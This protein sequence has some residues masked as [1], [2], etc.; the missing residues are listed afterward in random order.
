[1]KLF[2]FLFLFLNL[3]LLPL[4]KDGSSASDEE[5]EQVHFDFFEAMLFSNGERMRTFLTDD[6]TLHTVVSS[7]DGEPFLRQAD[8]QAFLESVENTKAGALDELL[9]SFNA[10]VDGDLATAWMAYRFYVVSD[11]SH[12]GVNTMNLIRQNSEWK[13]FS[14]VD[15]RRTNG[16]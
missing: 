9:I 15:T 16:C 10:H 14:I 5:I 4:L 7:D 13:I 3:N 1:M 12:C 11:F 8:I 2:V 6:A